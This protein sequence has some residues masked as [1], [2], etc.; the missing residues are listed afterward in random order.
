M[1]IGVLF[2]VVNEV[3]SGSVV[4]DGKV[5]IVLFYYVGVMYN[6]ELNGDL[7]NVSSYLFL[8]LVKFVGELLLVNVKVDGNFNSFDLIG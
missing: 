1:K 5:G 3:L 8:L 4:W 6:V 2:V 7:K